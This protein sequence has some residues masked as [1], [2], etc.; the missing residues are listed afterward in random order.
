MVRTVISLDPEDKRWLDQHAKET[1][2]SMT[3]V[4]RRAVHLYRETTSRETPPLADLLEQTRGLWKR[5]DGL[6]YQTGIRGEWDN[7]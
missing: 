5:G 7:S 6:S 2:V 3:E 1:H 4:V